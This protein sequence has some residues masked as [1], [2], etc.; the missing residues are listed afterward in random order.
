MDRIRLE[1]EE[2]D[3]PAQLMAG[4]EKEL[5]QSAGL[6]SAHLD[7]VLG[8]ATFKGA[9]RQQRLLRYLVE[10]HL[11]GGD[12]ELKEYSLGVEVFDKGADFDPR[13]DPIVRVEVSRLRN[14]LKKYYDSEGKEDSICIILPRGSY[15]P[16]FVSREEQ[17]AAERGGES[18]GEASGP[19]STAAPYR[20]RVIWIAAPAL[21]FIA[22]WLLVRLIPGSFSGESK[23]AGYSFVR[24][25][26][27]QARCTYPNLSPDGRLL[28]YARQD[29][30]GWNIYVR[31]VDSEDARILTAGS[32][33][34][35][36]QP[37]LSPDGNWIA[38]R[39]ERAGGG[40]FIMDRQGGNLR[41]LTGFGYHPAWS[42]D[43]RKIVF[44]T[45]TFAEPED[46]PRQRA[47]MLY[48]AE[49]STGEVKALT[50]PDRVYDAVQPSWSPGGKRIAFW[51]SGPDGKRD[52]WTIS[53]S[54]QSPDQ[55][56]AAPVTNDDWIDWSP[57][58]SP[59]GD[60]LYFTSDRDGAMNIWRIR[61]DEATGAV[62]GRPEPVR[63]PS[64]YSTM[65]SVDRTGRLFAYTRRTIS[66]ILHAVPFS[67]ASGADMARARKLTASGRQIREPELSPDGAWLSARAQDPEEDIVLLRPDG[68]IVRRLTDDKYKDRNA[69]WSP[70]GSHLLFLS[71]RGGTFEYWLMDRDGGG[72]RRVSEPMVL[73]WAPDG[74]LVGYPQQGTPYCVEPAV[75]ACPAA[76]LLPADFL[77]LAWAPDGKHVAGRLR[78]FPPPREQLL[79]YS[80]AEKSYV[81]VAEHGFSPVWAS[82]SRRLLFWEADKI[83]LWSPGFSSPRL[84]LSAPGHTLQQRFT[85]SADQRELVVSLTDVEEDIWLAQRR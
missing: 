28:Y 63:T 36:Y 2:G 64:S 13:L 48:L 58:W 71:N 82:D 25:T 54:V 70:D 79:V 21:V 18:L 76:A 34:D 66:S 51:G 9:W 35:D 7:K 27:E 72:L 39:S 22:A 8:S 65:V 74:S 20:M 68:A 1:F 31:P 47:S 49:V 12:S 42:P 23:N 15:V 81:Q 60:F 41:K 73:A 46:G 56:R 61:L 52:I 19:V 59:Q 14:R 55:I 33:A 17:K 80:L 24:L 84:V 57:A 26:R 50:S 53:A 75:P 40:I 29:A 77:P 37:A 30:D 69:R 16:R 4:T 67:F 83:W 43:G 44:S 11:K 45:H 85:L 62:R 10:R 38:F 5:S 3:K 78:S 6:A 32:S